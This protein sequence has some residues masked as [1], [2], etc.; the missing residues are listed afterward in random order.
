MD[1][2]ACFMSLAMK[3]ISHMTRL[4]WLILGPHFEAQVDITH[5]IS[6]LL[7]DGVLEILG[8]NGRDDEVEDFE[9]E[10]VLPRYKI[11][12][13]EICHRLKCNNTL[14]T[15]QLKF[16]HVEGSLVT[17]SLHGVLR[18]FNNTTLREINV[19]S[20][21]HHFT[22]NHDDALKTYDMIHDVGGYD[23]YIYAQQ[24]DFLARFNR[25]GRG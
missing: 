6:D 25:C 18:D 8:V 1:E 5:P 9:D 13:N 4:Q 20:Y 11:E 7:K 16:I 3:P 19:H 23:C 21:T 17:K 14:H 10:N 15:L 22:I 2:T 24:L 12:M